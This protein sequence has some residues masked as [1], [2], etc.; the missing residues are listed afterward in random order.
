M[1]NRSLVS[2]AAHCAWSFHISMLGKASNGCAASCFSTTTASASGNVTVITPTATPGKS[3]ATRAL[4]QGECQGRW[5]LS[6]KNLDSL[7]GQ[8]TRRFA[9]R[10]DSRP[11]T[12]ES[13]QDCFVCF[14]VW[15][16]PPKQGVSAKPFFPSSFS[17]AH[18]SGLHFW[19][20]FKSNQERN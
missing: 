20:H 19:S 8:K 12:L 13:S 17:R 5:E 6:M 10:I 16:K 9:P 18:F 2:T 4:E 7:H 1:A 15:R 14:R 11:P 3:N